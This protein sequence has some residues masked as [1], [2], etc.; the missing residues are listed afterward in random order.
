MVTL[1]QF[2]LWRLLLS[3]LLVGLTEISPGRQRQS[4]LH[5]MKCVSRLNTVLLQTDC[6]HSQSMLTSHKNTSPIRL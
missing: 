3:V 5:V 6:Q 2:A 4:E 1:S